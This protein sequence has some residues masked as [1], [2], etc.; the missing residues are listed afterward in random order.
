MSEI[1]N[2]IDENKSII[3]DIYLKILE[4][5]S[6][7]DLQED[8][9]E[10]TAILKIYEIILMELKEKNSFNNETSVL[11]SLIEMKDSLSTEL[12]RLNEI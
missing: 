10:V 8:V 5:N 11:I 7:K 12:F 1:N 3:S 4:F 9:K 2:L 6:D